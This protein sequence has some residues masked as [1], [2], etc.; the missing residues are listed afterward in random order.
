MPKEA[1]VDQRRN[2]AIALG[3][4]ARK[5]LFPNS[6]WPGE[7]P[8]AIGLSFYAQQRFRVDFEEGGERRFEA[9]HEFEAVLA[10]TLGESFSFFG[11]YTLFAGGELGGLGIYS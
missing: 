9:P 6:M 10:G 4:P 11:E 8:E 5:A 2:D 1:E 3:N 7:I